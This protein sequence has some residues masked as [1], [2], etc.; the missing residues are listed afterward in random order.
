MNTF[1]DSDDA[2]QNSFI[3]ITTAFIGLSF[4]ALLMEVQVT[5]FIVREF[6]QAFQSVIGFF[7]GRSPRF[8][9][10]LGGLIFFALPSCLLL[11]FALQTGSNISKASV[12]EEAEYWRTNS[13]ST[14]ST[15][16]HSI[17]LE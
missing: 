6:I 11:L 17:E 9:F 16:S 12:D 5:T 4:I 3:I 2:Y 1:H 7:Q 15:I 10:L 8:Y 13:H 14:P